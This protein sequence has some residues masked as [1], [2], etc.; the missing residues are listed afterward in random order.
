M[1]RRKRV[2][3]LDSA[4]SIVML[5]DIQDRLLSAMPDGVRAR[6]IEQIS[7]LLTAANVLDV[8]V[9]ITEQYPKGL[10]TTDNE[11]TKMVKSDVP[12]IE[13]T[14]FSCAQ[15]EAV[16]LH[17]EKQ[18][19]NKVVLV[20]METHICILQTA[21]DLLGMG[22]Q[23]YVLEDAVSSRSKSNQYNALQRMRAGGVVITNVESSL[24]EWIGDAQHPEFKTLA[25]LIH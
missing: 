20:G 13:K 10:G 12:I 23:V 18:G 19:R 6:M 25:K 5:V 22:Y 3:L 9:M 17:L 11:L 8:P 21:M 14:R 2:E 24:F 1:D 7:I 15:V 16:R 4:N